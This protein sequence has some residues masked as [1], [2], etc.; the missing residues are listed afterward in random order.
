MNNKI[1]IDKLKTENKEL[2][3]QI[4]VINEKLKES[5]TMKSHFLS[6]V[7]NEIINPLSSIISSSKNIFKTNDIQKSK[8]MANTIFSEAFDL[9]FQLKNIF[10]AAELEAG[11]SSPQITKLNIKDLINESVSI[12]KNKADKKKLIFETNISTKVHNN[13]FYT[14]SNMLILI[15]LNLLDN[16]I[17]YSNKNNTIF[18][19]VIQSKDNLNLKIED[20]GR[21]I[22]KDTLQKIFDRFTKSDKN[23]H[24]LNNG[25]GLGLSVSKA[26]IDIL[27]GKIDVKSKINQGSTFS[28][29][30]PDFKNIIEDYSQEETLFS[31]DE[32]F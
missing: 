15:L 14:D 29:N 3:K 28:I 9:D 8:N 4:K 24:S 19:N 31:E 13:S 12:M 7:M 16:A 32:L 23:V 10:T 26:L 21:G 22:E 25:H 6:N 11:I 27:D 20:S 17:K 2:T 1:E 18:I 5:E 30:I